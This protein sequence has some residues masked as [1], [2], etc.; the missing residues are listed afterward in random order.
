[1]L[2][3]KQ[4]DNLQRFRVNHNVVGR[5]NTINEDIL[6]VIRF[7]RCLVQSFVIF[8]YRTWWQDE[9]IEPRRVRFQR[10]ELGEH[11]FFKK[12]PGL[13]FRNHFAVVAWSTVAIGLSLQHPALVSDDVELDA[14]DTLRHEIRSSAL[15]GPEGQNHRH[16]IDIFPLMSFSAA[17]SL[18]MRSLTHSSTGDRILLLVK[19]IGVKVKL[20]DDVF[21]FCVSV[22]FLQEC[23][24]VQNG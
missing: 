6:Y 5:Q 4:T 1:M 14:R 2:P 3:I 24:E 23:F 19:V 9:S 22:M 16:Q 21:Q 7:Y 20:E 8:Q 12:P 11:L 18:R 13:C 10:R 15:V 17:A